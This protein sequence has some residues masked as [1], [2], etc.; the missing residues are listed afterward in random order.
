M[1]RKDAIKIIS[2]LADNDII[3]SANGFLSRDLFD[4]F[5]K[6]SNFYM[7]GSMGLASSIGLG[8]AI[9]NPKKRVFVF[10]GDGN[11]LMNLGSLT[12]IGSLKPKNLVHVI[13]DNNS[14]ES[15]GGQPS[16]SKN[17]KI[18]KIGE[19]ANYKVYNTNT[20]LGFKQVL[21]KI[22]NNSGPIMIIVKIKAKKIISQ[23]ITH[24]PIKIRDR[25]MKSLEKI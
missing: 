17:V 1:I 16:N 7:L 22:K 21:K 18:G 8:V 9:K 14:H 5:D 3:I 24:R 2:K 25:F 4:L 13:F 12:T 10:D 15:T 6:P 11:I 23:R 20:K 19:S